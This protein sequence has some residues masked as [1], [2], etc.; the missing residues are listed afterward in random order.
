MVF[1]NEV[2]ARPSRRGRPIVN[3]HCRREFAG[4][5]VSALPDEDGVSDLPDPRC[6]I[7]PDRGRRARAR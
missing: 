1:D 2:T 3:A 5:H 6:F 7:D 4:W